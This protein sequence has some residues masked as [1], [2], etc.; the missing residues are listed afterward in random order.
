MNHYTIFT[1]MINDAVDYLNEVDEVNI[2]TV[3]S[4]LA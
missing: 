2:Q 3:H 1:A 4:Y